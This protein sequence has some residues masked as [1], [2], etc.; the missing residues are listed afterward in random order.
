MAEQNKDHAASRIDTQTLAD[1]RSR[2]EA[3][4]ERLLAMVATEEENTAAAAPEDPLTA[5]VRDYEEQALDITQE[6]IELALEDNDRRQF[7]QVE[8]A[9]RRMDEGT[10]GLSEI[11]G[12]P[13]PLE[14]LQALPWATTNV[15]D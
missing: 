5:D 9:L 6:D 8:K 12:A 13:I 11:S 1:L 15:G 4:R 3:E 14:R 7:A 2:L 10:Y